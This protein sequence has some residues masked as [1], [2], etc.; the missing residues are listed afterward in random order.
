MAAQSRRR[1]HPAAAGS[2]PSLADV[3]R[4]AGVST[5]S[6]SRALARSA[7]VSEA[8]L[9]RVSDAAT[10]LGYVANAAARALSTRKSGL[11]GAVLCDAAD[12]VSLQMLEAAERTLSAQGMG[13]LIRVVCATAPASACARALGARGVDGLLW[14]G[15]VAVSDT[16]SARMLPY[17]VCGQNPGRD[18]A[19]PGETFAHRGLA[20]ACAYLQRL[21]HGR[22]GLIG[23]RCEADAGGPPFAPENVTTIEQRV[24]TL[25]DADA[26]RAGAR[27][28]IRNAATAIVAASDLAAAAALRECRALRVAVPQQVSVVGWGDSELARCLDPGLTSIRVPACAGGQCAAE[29]LIAALAGH[30]FAWPELPLKLVIRDSTGPVPT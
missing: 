10:R 5:A 22:I 16:A 20:L 15:N 14:I 24:P 13:V 26:M 7:L 8:V 11:I 30:S 28:L 29:Y 2:P 12:P 21:G 19:R 3:A 25:Y 27:L 4:A 17:V 9:A 18:D 6:A 23:P 1:P